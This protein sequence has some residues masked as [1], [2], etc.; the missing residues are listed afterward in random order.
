MEN[1]FTLLN[2]TLGN[3]AKLTVTLEEVGEVKKLR[4][5]IRNQSMATNSPVI[6]SLDSH[7]NYQIG[8]KAEVKA[9][10]THLQ[11]LVKKM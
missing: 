10:I 3:E 5:E 9:L 7:L 6:M 2:P 1:E 4:M 8:T 11:G